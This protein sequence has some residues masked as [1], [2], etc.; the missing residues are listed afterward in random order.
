M[1]SLK[2]SKKQLLNTLIYEKVKGKPI[3]YRNYEKVLKGELSPEAIMGSSDLHAFLVFI[4]S[5]LIGKEIDLGK[6]IVATG[7]LGFYTSEDSFRL[8]D[9]AIFEKE[10]FKF[11]GGYTKT[12]PKV[13][14]EI[15]TKADLK[16]YASVENYAFEK[17][18]ELIDAGVEKVIWIFTKPKKV[19]I[20][21]K[22]KKWIVQNWKDDFEVI[23]K[24]K[25]NLN[26]ILKN[27]LR[28]FDDVQ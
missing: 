23:D 10:K 4:I 6:Y 25:V 12:P 5:F 24:I 15:D 19:M 13:T 28:R 27:T 14:I 3:Y 2:E 20:A 26:E 17:T 18:Q 8:L 7:E 21:E 11:S 1:T 22:G 9:I 16:D